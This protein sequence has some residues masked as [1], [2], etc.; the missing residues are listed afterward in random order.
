M[1]VSIYV[2]SSRRLVDNGAGL[3]IKFRVR[4]PQRPMVVLGKPSK[5]NM[6]LCYVRKTLQC[7]QHHKGTLV[8]PLKRKKPL[9][10]PR[11]RMKEEV[12]SVSSL[13]WYI[14]VYVYVCMCACDTKGTCF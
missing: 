12:K 6:L 13:C 9:Q 5:L 3:V 10:L 2:E 7:C 14:L 8:T 11:L 1:Y 4:I